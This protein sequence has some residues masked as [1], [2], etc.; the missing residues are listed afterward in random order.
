MFVPILALM[1]LGV[2]LTVPMRR[3]ESWIATWK[4]AIGD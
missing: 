3:L 2:T 1:L 4:D